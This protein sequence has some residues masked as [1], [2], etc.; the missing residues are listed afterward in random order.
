[1]A[2]GGVAARA[3]RALSVLRANASRFASPVVSGRPVAAMVVADP[4]ERVRLAPSVRPV[5]ASRIAYP[6][7][8]GNPVVTTAVAVVAD[9]V[10][11]ARAA[12][13]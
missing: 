3:T 5:S 12:T 6:V 11:L 2:V 9:R 1:M 4:V 8:W 13:L 7:V 10:R